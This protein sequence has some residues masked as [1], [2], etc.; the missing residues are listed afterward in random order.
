[1]IYGVNGLL[2]ISAIILLALS[3]SGMTPAEM[4]EDIGKTIEV[5]RRGGEKE[6]IIV[7]LR[8]ELPAAGPTSR[9]APTPP[10]ARKPPDMS[11]PMD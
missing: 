9:P 11:L 3:T 7:P 1:V 10:P 8:G 5:I 6:T 4:R 2:Q